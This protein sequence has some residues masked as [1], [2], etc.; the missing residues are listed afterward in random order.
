ML[1]KPEN[2]EYHRG[3]GSQLLCRHSQLLSELLR[4]K[5]QT[6]TFFLLTSE[7]QPF[8]VVDNGFG[9]HWVMGQSA[10]PLV[11]RPWTLI[12]RINGCHE[13]ILLL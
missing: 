5:L 6:K 3:V 12:P 4:K 7:L 10:Q 1:D 11:V 2:R 8:N 13:L 9:C